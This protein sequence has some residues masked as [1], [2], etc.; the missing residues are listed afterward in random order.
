MESSPLSLRK[1]EDGKGREREVSSPL[2]GK[3]SVAGICGLFPFSFLLLSR[4]REIGKE[5][6][7]KRGQGLWMRN[8]KEKE[9]SSW[10]PIQYFIITF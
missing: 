5:T 1:R 8:R 2:S 3:R 6:E 10:A 4:R 9:I 7:E